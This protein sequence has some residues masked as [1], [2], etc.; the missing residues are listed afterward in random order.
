M[1]IANT[2]PS[3]LTETFKPTGPCVSSTLLLRLNC[4]HLDCYYKTEDIKRTSWVLNAR[5]RNV[6]HMLENLI[7]KED[8]FSFQNGW[9]LDLLIALQPHWHCSKIIALYYITRYIYVSF[10]SKFCSFS[11]IQEH[12]NCFIIFQACWWS[13]P[14][15][16][17]RTHLKFLTWLCWF[18]EG[19]GTGALAWETHLRFVHRERVKLEPESLES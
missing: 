7:F 3:F 5:C 4:M 6:E 8:W 17:T 10:F 11:M 16:L 13:S 9:K 12:E 18:W 15:R 14:H 1:I 19:T 2:Y